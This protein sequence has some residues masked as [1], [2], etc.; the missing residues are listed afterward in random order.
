MKPFA[1]EVLPCSKRY[2][3]LK[4]RFV[5]RHGVLVAPA[6]RQ[7]RAS[8]FEKGDEFEASPCTLLRRA[9]RD[10]DLE[11]VEPDVAVTSSG[12]RAQRGHKDEQ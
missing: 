1:S 10:K 3:V 12:K 6:R 2:R 9:V 8:E 5:F 4:D 11:L 7:S